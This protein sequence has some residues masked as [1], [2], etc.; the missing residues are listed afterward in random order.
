MA[1]ATS[2]FAY[3]TSAAGNNATDSSNFCPNQTAENI[4]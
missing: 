1:C 3:T 4:T 2:Y